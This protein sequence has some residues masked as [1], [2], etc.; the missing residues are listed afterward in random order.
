MPGNCRM[1]A[2]AADSA[3]YAMLW[4]KVA[5]VLPVIRRLH[6]LIQEI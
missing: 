5:K 6:P 1:M 2:G 4:A 3:D